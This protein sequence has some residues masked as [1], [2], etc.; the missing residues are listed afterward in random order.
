M[1]VTWQSHDCHIVQL[2][3]LCCTG[4]HRRR[5]AR[6]M[7]VGYCL[8]GKAIL[9]CWSWSC[10]SH[11]TMRWPCPLVGSQHELCFLCAVL[12]RSATQTCPSLSVWVLKLR[13]LLWKTSITIWWMCLS[14]METTWSGYWRKWHTFPWAWVSRMLCHLSTSTSAVWCRV[15]VSP[16]L[17]LSL[18]LSLCV[19]MCVCACVH[20]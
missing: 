2:V 20:A 19:C 10:D 17:S 8:C 6:C 14:L 11:M 18:S 13:S 9:H 1:M 7:L 15:S 3:P 4:T 5:V 12:P 16:S